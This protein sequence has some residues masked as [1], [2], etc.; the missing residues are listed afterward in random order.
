V[1]RRTW[2]AALAVCLAIVVGSVALDVAEAAPSVSGPVVSLDRSSVQVG[3]RILVKMSG[4]SPA[5]LTISVCGNEARRGSSDCNMRS[6]EGLSTVGEEGTVQRQITV[7]EPPADCPCVVRV[8]NRDLDEIAIA[9]LEIVGHPTGPLVDPPVQGP[10]VEVVV[11]ARLAPGGFVRGIRADLGGPATYDVTVSVRN[12]T[13]ASLQNVALSGSASRGNGDTL[14]PL[15]FD[16]PGL[17]G[18]GQTWQQTIKARVP[19]PSFGEIHWEVTASG[20][21]SIVT[22]SADTAHRPVL[23]VAMGGFAL[24]C[25]LLMVVRWRVRRHALRAERA[26]LAEREGETGDA[27]IEEPVVGAPTTVAAGRSS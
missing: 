27:P 9:P 14:V 11:E 2:A 26:E 12:R 1:S 13:T 23:L 3:D 17:I 16:A 18:V 7:P 15:D 4:F 10:L 25:L 6:S 21:G 22:A 5:T 8:S 20:S 19:A 24:L